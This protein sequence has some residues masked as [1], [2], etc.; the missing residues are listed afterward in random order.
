MLGANVTAIDR[1]PLDPR[2]AA[3]PT[4]TFQQGSAFGLEPEEMPEADWVFSDIIAYPKRLLA[5]AT[6]WINAGRAKHLTDSEISGRN[7]PR[8]CCRF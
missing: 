5:L 2:V 4:V 7:R 8:N 1:A 3:M 6:R